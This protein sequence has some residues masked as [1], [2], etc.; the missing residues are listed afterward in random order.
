MQGGAAIDVWK[1]VVKLHPSLLVDR[2]IVVVE[3]IHPSRQAQWTP[4]PAERQ[5]RLERQKR[6]FETVARVTKDEE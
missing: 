6:A 1:R 5:A 3:S 2:G 4:D